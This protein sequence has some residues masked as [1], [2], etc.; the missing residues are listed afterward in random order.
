MI[1]RLE[2]FIAHYRIARR[3]CSASRAA[4]VALA[5]TRLL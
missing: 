5:F 3:Y 1:R 4:S 2:L